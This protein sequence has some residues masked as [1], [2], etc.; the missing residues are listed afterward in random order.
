MLLFAFATAVL[1]ALVSAVAPS[2]YATSVQPVIALKQQSTAV[3]GGLNLRK[4]L[5]A[6]QFALALILLIGAGLFARTLATLRARGPG[7]PTT[8]LLMFQV[9]PLS[10]GYDQAKSTPLMRRLLVAVRQLPEVEQAGLSGYEMLR[11]GGWNN[12]VTIQSGQRTVTEDIGMNAVSPGFFAAL[13]ARVTRGRDFDDRDTR[14][15][16][17]D[18]TRPVIV[19]EEF[20]KRYLKSWDPLSSRLGIGDKPDTVAGAQIV[21]VVRSFHDF[22]LRKPEAQVFFPWVQVGWW[23]GTFYVR[24]RSSSQA[25]VRSIRAAIARIDPAL[26]VLSLRTIDDQLDRM[27]TN[28]RMLAALAGGFAAV[29][30]LLAMIGLY[31]V[32]SFSAASRTREIG[33]RL[34]LGAPRWSA[35]GLIIREAAVLALA[36]LAVAIPVSWA[37]GRFVENQ[38]FG[39]R[40]M[41]AI[42]IAGAA[43]VLAIVCLAAS[44]V[45][46]RRAGSVSPLETLR[47][48]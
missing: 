42:S 34:A 8:N 9:D 12:P 17:G 18:G 29:A 24:S 2:L 14:D 41:D 39:V 15:D 30:T 7:F 6:G 36:G 43:A 31:G 10:D 3:A 26:T 28:E 47:S 25:A 48:E 11:G 20:V 23:P 19:N 21:G 38:L 44:A 35:G 16:G 13:G 4:A 32:L 22:D 37:L 5:V 45:P 33:I 1:T 46:A 40:P 27:L